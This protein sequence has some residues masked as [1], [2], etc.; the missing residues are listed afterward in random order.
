MLPSQKIEL[1]IYERIKV[2]GSGAVS[3]SLGLLVA[4]TGQ[5]HAT[6]VER[7]KGLDDERRISLTKYSGGN[8]EPRDRFSGDTAFFYH[9]GF[10]VRFFHKGGNTLNS[11]KKKP[12]RKRRSD[13]FSLAVASTCGRRSSLANN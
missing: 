13:W 9:K 8:P 7:L 12:L 10:R 4:A 1:A 2:L 11:L 5:D 6:L 3:M